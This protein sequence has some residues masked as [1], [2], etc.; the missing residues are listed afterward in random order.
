MIAVDTNLLVR[1]MTRD[2]PAQADAALN[3]MRGELALIAPTVLLETE[4]VLRYSYGFD[5]AQVNTAL[6]RVA[7]LE[8]AV[9]PEQQAVVLA[10]GWHR[11]GMDFGDAL[12]LALGRAADSFV[13]FD[14]RLARIASG[15]AGTPPVE[16]LVAG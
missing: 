10:L 6:S 15:L 7:N 8:S 14:R 9:V 5:R 3:R 11:Q 12:H 1:V 16:Q 13:T 2:D 4:W